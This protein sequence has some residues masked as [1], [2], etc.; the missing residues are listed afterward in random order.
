[1][2]KFC[3]HVASGSAAVQR[4]I[5]TVNELLELL[6]K[7]T[8]VNPELATDVLYEAWTRAKHAANL[9]EIEVVQAQ[10]AIGLRR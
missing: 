5:S 1:M 3:E 9:L 6:A 4:E 8:F 7:G 10:R 2:D